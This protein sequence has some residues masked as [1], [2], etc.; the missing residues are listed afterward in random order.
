MGQLRRAAGGDGADGEDGVERRLLAGHLAEERVELH[1]GQGVGLRGEVQ[2]FFVHGKAQRHIGPV[3]QQEDAAR[4]ADFLK[5]GLVHE[6]AVAV[7]QIFDAEQ[8]V[9]KGVGL[10][11]GVAVAARAGGQADALQEGGDAAVRGRGEDAHAVEAEEG[12]LIERVF[13][14]EF[15]APEVGGVFLARLHLLD[16]GVGRGGLERVVGGVGGPDLV[17]ALHRA[18]AGLAD[19]QDAENPQQQPL[20]HH[21]HGEEDQQ[22]AEQNRRRQRGDEHH[23]RV[24]AV[25]EDQIQQPAQREHH[26]RHAPPAQGVQLRIGAVGHI[27]QHEA[28]QEAEPVGKLV[29]EVEAVPDEVERAEDEAAAEEEQQRHRGDPLLQRNLAAEEEEQGKN[30][31]AEAAGDVRIAVHRGGLHAVGRVRKDIAEALQREGERLQPVA[32]FAQTQGEHRVVEAGPGGRE[33]AALGEL[34]RL[35]AEEIKE[36]VAFLA[37]DVLREGLAGD[38]VGLHHVQRLRLRELVFAVRGGLQAQIG[39][40]GQQGRHA[41]GQQGEDGEAEQPQAKAPQIVPVDDVP[42]DEDQQHEDADEEA[43]VVAAEEREKEAEGIERVAPVAEQA[44][45]A[46]DH[47]RQQGDRVE[48]DRVPVVAHDEAAQGVHRGENGDGQLAAVKGL[49]QEKG[50]EGAGETHPDQNRCVV[51][52]HDGLRGQQDRD[53]IQR[54]GQIVGKERQ[55]ARAHAGGPGVEQG[56]AVQKPGAQIEIEGIVL[57]PLIVGEDHPGAEGL[58]LVDRPEHPHNQHGEEEGDQIDKDGPSLLCKEAAAGLNA[59]EGK[60][61]RRFIHVFHLGEPAYNAAAADAA[62]V[63]MDI[64]VIVL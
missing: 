25:F 50:E 45:R 62:R 43:D 41:H 20:A 40:H 31:R 9:R 42:E 46:H 49:A 39:G 47:Q 37:G 58:D 21:A 29:R 4:P 32:V 34:G 53:Q 5:I 38:A 55:I 60:T 63:K 23:Q 19:H 12:A 10:L 13:G 11:V 1:I 7:D 57:V 44:D 26:Q 48:P 17:H 8:E 51:P 3:L 56:V 64:I 27:D 61:A 52:E 30:Q 54:A 35:A 33:R 22:G 2:R 36:L 16:Q 18:E 14:G 6:A 24:A 59:A 15:G 28:P